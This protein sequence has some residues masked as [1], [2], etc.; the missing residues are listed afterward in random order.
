MKPI[1]IF[2]IIAVA[3]TSSTAVADPWKFAVMADSNIIDE[4]EDVSLG[5]TADILGMLVS[6]LKQQNI[7]LVIFPGDLAERED[8]DSLDEILTLW[9][10]QMKP[11][12]D[13]GIEVYTVRGNH[14]IPSSENDL[15]SDPYI[16][17][18]PLAR[19]ATS[20][21]GGFT[22]AFTHKNVK[23][24][25]FDEYVNQKASFDDHLY[26]IHSNQGQMMNSWVVS[27]I[28]DN[29]S[30]LNFAF[31]HEPLF[32]SESHHDCMAN[33]PD[34]RDAL[35][36]A[37]GTH[38][39]AYFCGHDHMYLRGTASDG[40]GHTIPEFVVGT[41]GGRI[42]DYAPKEASGYTG[43]DTFSAEKVYG[44]SKDPHYGYLLI[45]VYDNNT[46]SGQFKGMK[47][48]Q[49]INTKTL[50]SFTTRQ[51]NGSQVIV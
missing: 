41:A 25:G 31:A 44:N 1:I 40:E 22:Y 14:D 3:A 47:G 26:S 6:D 18:F 50:D 34:S 2:I 36:A 7:D 16:S 51:E 28:S 33:D 24:I 42:Y 12:Y 15:S 35:I 17:H 39:G 21:D 27:Q 46:W 45:T 48:N 10:S 19:N 9:K 29:T 30:P 43:P 23:F 32:P 4:D 37:L 49:P 5:S 11:L 13:A 8:H 38:N 20:P